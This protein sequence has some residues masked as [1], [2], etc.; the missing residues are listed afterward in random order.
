MERGS[1]PVRRMI[2]VANSGDGP[3]VEVGPIPRWTRSGSATQAPHSRNAALTGSG[4]APRGPRL[5]TVAT[6]SSAFRRRTGQGRRRPH[7]SGE[8]QESPRMRIT[9]SH[10]WPSMCGPQQH[11]TCAAAWLSSRS[12]IEVPVLDL[13]VW[14]VM[15]IQSLDRQLAAPDALSGCGTSASTLRIARSSASAIG[16]AFRLA[17]ERR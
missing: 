11:P 16:C 15:G 3:G 9:S 17:C 12:A 10:L 6:R 1:R 14:I 5:E 7:T 4:P 2:A 13:Q 8:G